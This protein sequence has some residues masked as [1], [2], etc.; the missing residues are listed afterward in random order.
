MS[1]FTQTQWIALQQPLI[2]VASMLTGKPVAEILAMEVHGR[3]VLLHRISVEAAELLGAV[4]AGTDPAGPGGVTLT[5]AEV[6][7]I[8]DEANDI[9]EAVKALTSA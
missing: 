7:T 6:A 8:V 9:P 5:E 4:A 3:A 2:M 1:S